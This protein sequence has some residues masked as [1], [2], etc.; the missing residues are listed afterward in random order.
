MATAGL[1]AGGAVL[2]S[3]LVTTDAPRGLPP[4]VR[5]TAATTAPP[6]VPGTPRLPAAPPDRLSIR[7]IGLDTRIEAVGLAPNGSVA[8]PRDADQAAWYADSPTP[9]ANGNA[10]L[11]GH[12]DSAVGPAAFYR[13]HAVEPGDL[14]EITRRDGRSVH[15]TVRSVRVWPADGFPSEEVYALTADPRLTILTCAEWDKSTRS[16]RSNLVITASP[17]TD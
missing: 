4:P 12:V 14:I 15:F 9:G 7:A 11:A 2:A 6:F 5:D 8:M 3:S 10:I 16:Y 17:H 1:F 13:L